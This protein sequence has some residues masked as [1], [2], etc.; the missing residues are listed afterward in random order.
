MHKGKSSAIF[1]LVLYFSPR[2]ICLYPNE[3]AVL[4]VRYF[5]LHSIILYVSKIHFFALSTHLLNKQMSLFD[6]LAFYNYPT[7]VL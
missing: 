7:T 2:V 5:I 6:I 4:S 3:V 1:N